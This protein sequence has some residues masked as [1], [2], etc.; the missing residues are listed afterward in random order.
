VGGDALVI[1]GALSVPVAELAAVHEGA[2][3]A[4]FAA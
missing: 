3:P 2:L 4:A 1:D